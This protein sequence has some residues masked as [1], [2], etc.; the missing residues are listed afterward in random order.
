MNFR[1]RPQSGSIRPF[2]EREGIKHLQPTMAFTKTVYLEGD[3]FITVG[4]WQST[5]G[6]VATSSTEAISG[7]EV[8]FRRL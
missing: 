6:P 7:A 3:E 4:V 1:H 5:G 8:V 2:V